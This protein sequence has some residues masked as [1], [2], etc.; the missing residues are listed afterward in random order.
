M[1]KKVF[2]LL[3]I[4]FAVLSCSPEITPEEESQMAVYVVD[5]GNNRFEAGTILNLTKVNIAFNSIEI[6]IISDPVEG[7]NDGAVSLF[8]EPTNE[9]IFEG[10]INLEGN[11]SIN[12][13]GMT[14]GADF[15]EIDSPISLNSRTI[16]DIGGPYN[17]SITPV[18]GAID[19]LGLTEIFLSNGA[20]IGRFLYKPA[21][22]NSENWK[23]IILLFDQ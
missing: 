10:S 1:M 22:D 6:D 14:P 12:F 3:S 15:F 11:A 9:K 16:E 13:P 18:W 8:Y 21:E 4:A 2:I 23:W 19:Q 17:E 20:M 7:E 5:Y